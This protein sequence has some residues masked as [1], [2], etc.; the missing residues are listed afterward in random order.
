[1]G[2][3]LFLMDSSGSILPYEF[4]GLKEFVVDLLKP[5]T[6]GPKDVQIGFVQVSD[7]PVVEFPFNKYTSN[8]AVQWALL[9]MKQKLGDTNT[10]KALTHAKDTMFTQKAGARPDVP[11]VLVWLTDGVS[12][13][14][15]SEP[16][17]L[18]KDLGVTV[19]IV[20]T[21]RGN[22]IELKAAAS[23]PSESHLYYVDPDD[24]YVIMEEL[25]NEILEIIQLKKLRALDITAS[26]FRLLWPKLLS[27]STGYY[28][29]EYSPLMDSQ[30]KSWKT[31]TGD[32]TSVVLR[33]LLPETTYEVKLTPINTN[34]N[35]Y[36]VTKVTTLEEEMS[37]Q[38]V[39]I[40]ESQPR[41]FHVSWAPTPHNV[42]SYEVLYGI[43][44]G[45]ETNLLTVSGDQNTTIVNN[46]EPNTTYLVTVS[47]MYQSGRTEALSV[48]ACTQDESSKVRKLKL[49]NISP[50][51]V[52]ALWDP[53]RGKVLQYRVQ[54]TRRR[55]SPSVRTVP[56]Q[57]RGVLLT[58]LIPGTENRICVKA[59]Y[60][61]GVGRALCRTARTP[62]Q[63]DILSPEKQST[64]SFC[65]QKH[66]CWQKR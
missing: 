29:I 65:T 6:I 24:M 18:L 61:N 33:Q 15:I 40:S 8:T 34:H 22:Y 11:K 27:D 49:I 28:L 21:G 44:P 63:Q 36:L 4:S 45:G 50:T 48:K 55:R 20:S 10:G 57:V 14:D 16:V 47:A 66:Q 58:D 31:V 9:N 43:L 38:V 39:V 26:S 51:G 41:S 19:F 56:A 37:P 13:D 46:L 62:Q 2:D 53:A 52:A 54:C 23:E 60:R 32:E 3:L 59:V 17:K 12:S 42:A 64:K 25:R 5:F 7:D 35:K 30:S 1:M